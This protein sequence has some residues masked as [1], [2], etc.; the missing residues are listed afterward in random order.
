MVK[1]PHILANVEYVSRRLLTAQ[2]LLREVKGH[3]N[4]GAA[5]LVPSSCSWTPTVSGGHHTGYH[6]FRSKKKFR[7]PKDSRQVHV[8]AKGH[9]VCKKEMGKGTLTWRERGTG[10]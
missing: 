1:T 8:C 4:L 9:T 2:L 10:R 5:N 3:I 6:F 7:D